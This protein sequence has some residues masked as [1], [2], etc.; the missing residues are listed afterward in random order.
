MTADMLTKP[1]QG[2][3]FRKFRSR[4]L[5]LPGDGAS[6]ECVGNDVITDESDLVG[7]TDGP[8]GPVDHHCLYGPDDPSHG[9]IEIVNRGKRGKRTRRS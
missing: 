6:Q 5:N 1:L 7:Q 9:W 8:L 2:G 3:L 4:L